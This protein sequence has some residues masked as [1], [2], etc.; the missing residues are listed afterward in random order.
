[1]SQPTQTR[2]ELEAALIAKAQANPAFRQALVKN[3]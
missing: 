3:P 2:K 1:M